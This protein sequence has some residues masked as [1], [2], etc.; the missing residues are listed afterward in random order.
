MSENLNL[1]FLRESNVEEEELE[2]A[3]KRMRGKKINIT[4]PI[5]FNLS[6]HS[7]TT[8]Q[9]NNKAR[10]HWHNSVYCLLGWIYTT[11]TLL[12]SSLSPAT[13]RRLTSIGGREKTCACRML[14]VL[15]LMLLS[16]CLSIRLANNSNNQ[17][18]ISI[19]QRETMKQICFITWKI[20]NS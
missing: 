18:L 10:P 9:I 20:E 3:A 13:A 7:S 2:E 16:H 14:R 11:L 6:V 15:M 4:T 12:F 5:I 17:L 1:F 19:W 8:E